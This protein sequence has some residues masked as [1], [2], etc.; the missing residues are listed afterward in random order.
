M[1]YA[2]VSDIHGNLQ[3]WKQVWASLAAEKVDGVICLGDIVGYGPR[4]AETL[5]SVKS[6][7]NFC[8]IG[9]HD[10]VIVGLEDPSRFNEDAQNLIHWSAERLDHNA[11]E[12]FSEMPYE[13]NLDT[14]H[15]VIRCVHGSPFE[16]EMF[17]Y[18]SNAKE[19]RMAW[20]STDTQIT[21]IGHSH[22]P[23]F[24][25]LSP[26]NQVKYRQG[27][28]LL[29]PIEEGTR[30]IINAGS[31]G[32]S[33]DGDSRAAYCIYDSETRTFY[34]RRVDFDLEEYRRDVKNNMPD[35]TMA[36]FVLDN[37]ELSVETQSI[38]KFTNF[39]PSD[40][41]QRLTINRKAT[42]KT[43]NV[44]KNSIR[45]RKTGSTQNIQP[46]KRNKRPN[47][48]KTKLII[49]LISTILLGGIVAAI[50]IIG[51]KKPPGPK[52]K[53]KTKPLLNQ[54][55]VKTEPV[56]NQNTKPPPKSTSDLSNSIMNAMNGSPVKKPEQEV[57]PD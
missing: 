15:G 24:F 51:N 25:T 1:K 20:D 36:A 9:N 22:V 46:I 54:I 26:D 52:V 33:R 48:S 8:V 16:P 43:I 47:T 37:F 31:V 38:K 6:K 23:G 34:W 53:D 45:R 14:E 57:N 40:E 44:R 55:P 39:N 32:L 41:T 18:V 3:A 27:N 42:I 2:F 12:Y 29:Y 11:K 4:P 35:K 19:A 17:W 30:Y 49:F 13:L 28:N 7:V 50:L 10:A 56:Q 21:F 5:A